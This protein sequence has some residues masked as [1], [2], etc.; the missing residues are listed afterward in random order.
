M[1]VKG[2]LGGGGAVYLAKCA[3]LGLTPASQVRMQR[4]AREGG[5]LLCSAFGVNRAALVAS[6]TEGP[7]RFAC[8]PQAGSLPVAVGPAETERR[9]L[10]STPCQAQVLQQLTSPAG[11]MA[12]CSL[13]RGG[14]AA[15][16]AALAANT[17]LTALDLRDNN[18]DPEVG[19][20]CHASS[21]HVMTS[22]LHTHALLLLGKGP[23]NPAAVQQWWC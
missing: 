17:A 13:G 9:R 4:C 16:G 2:S 15:L 3:E 10:P 12:H 20:C 21:P 11:A 6:T 5:E 14:A 18:L 23:C 8:L 1:F 19:R 22:C 7:L